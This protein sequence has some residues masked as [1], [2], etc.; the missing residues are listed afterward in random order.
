MAKTK[1][2]TKTKVKKNHV[3]FILDASGS[4]SS[5]TRKTTEVCNKLLAELKEKSKTFN[6]PTTVSLYDFDD[7]LVTHFENVNIKDVVPMNRY[8]ARGSTAMLDAFGQVA[9]KVDLDHDYSADDSVLV[10]VLTDG[11]EN[12]SRSFNAQ[13]ITSLIRRLQATDAWTITFQVPPG[14]SSI[15]TAYGVPA[16]NI[17]EWEA[18]ELGLREV[19]QKTSGG[20]DS[21]YLSRSVGK[22]SVRSFYSNAA[23]VPL[24][25]VQKVL[26][27]VSKDFLAFSVT[28]DT[29]IKDFVETNAKKR[30]VKGEGF[31]QLMKPEIVQSNKE[32]LIYDKKH[33]KLYY[34]DAARNL[35]GLPVGSDIKVIPGNHGQYEIFVES[36][37][38][39]RKLKA[40]TKLLVKK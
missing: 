36:T 35:I 26:I 13:T 38:V 22:T 31:Y 40:G 12:A 30:Y 28:S 8:R 29:P 20:L 7:K 37:S 33:R 19:E 5:L 17:S 25:K 24:A 34:G 9:T 11:Y 23:N 1:K 15:L 18:S 6:Q 14:S 27:D 39:N 2:K 32:I 4:M 21:Y 16:G 3:I 10:F